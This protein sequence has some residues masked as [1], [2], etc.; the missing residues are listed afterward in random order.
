[1][2][3]AHGRKRN[4]RKRSCSGDRPAAASCRREAARRGKAPAMSGEPRCLRH[5]GPRPSGRRTARSP[6]ARGRR[7][8]RSCSAAT[9]STP[10]R[11]RRLRDRLAGPRRAPRARRRGQDA[12]PRADHRRPL[13][14]RG[15]RRG[16]AGHPGIVTLY[17]AGVD[18]DG[19]YLVSE[20]VRGA[21]LDAAA[22][23]RA[24]VGPRH[25]R[26]SGS[27]CAT[28]SRTRTPR[29]SSTATSSPRTCSSP[30]A[31]RA[32]RRSPS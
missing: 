10:P 15:P 6:R 24:A 26:G 20:L 28:R 18:D 23:G 4:T 8:A 3:G 14:A 7:T 31:R 25:R 9:A 19:A 29:A 1:M 12:P 22:R 21:T 32:G 17:E 5:R 2:T 27:R 11:R 16:A 13:R 30:S